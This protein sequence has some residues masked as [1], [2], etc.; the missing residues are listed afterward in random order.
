MRHA[1]T[2]AERLVSTLQRANADA[3]EVAQAVDLFVEALLSNGKGAE[4]RTR[5]LAEQVIQIRQ[6][7]ASP[8]DPALA[9]SLRNLGDVLVQR[10]QYQ[11]ARPLYERARHIRERTVDATHPDLADDLD[12]LANL[13]I[14]IEKYDEAL[15]VSE[16][17]LAIKEMS[18]EPVDLRIARTLEVRGLLF[19]RRGDYPRARE[20]F[21]RAL[22]L[23]ELAR[24]FASRCGRHAERWRTKSDSRAILRIQAIGCPGSC[25][26]GRHT[27][28]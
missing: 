15:T 18:L 12:R 22:S 14:Q 19:Q 23:R 27:Q 25:H 5:E 7:R 28:T 4:T 20:S 11:L 17:A 1:E 2:E 26:C 24:S 8:D 21:E 9:S 6:L 13:L 3:S 16:Q 10:S